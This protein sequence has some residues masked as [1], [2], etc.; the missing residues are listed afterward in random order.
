MGREEQGQAMPWRGRTST[1]RTVYYYDPPRVQVEADTEDAPAGDEDA[2]AGNL[3][4]TKQQR[5]ASP[6]Q[7]ERKVRAAKK[8]LF[9]TPNRTFVHSA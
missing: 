8:K 3:L 4:R 1:H 2:V 9:V 5:R 7:Q 6:P